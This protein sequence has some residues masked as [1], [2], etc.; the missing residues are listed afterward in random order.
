MKQAGKKT[1]DSYYYSFVKACKL[2][3]V[4]KSVFRQAITSIRKE[5]PASYLVKLFKSGNMHVKPTDEGRAVIMNFLIAN[6]LV[7]QFVPIDLSM[8]FDVPDPPSPNPSTPI[9]RSRSPDRT[10]RKTPPISDNMKAPP[11]SQLAVAPRA[12]RPRLDKPANMNFRQN[13]G[14]LRYIFLPYAQ[15]CL[16]TPITTPITKPITKP[17]TQVIVSRKLVSPKVGFEELLSDDVLASV[18]GAGESHPF[19]P[20]AGTPPRTPPRQVTVPPTTKNPPPLRTMCPYCHVTLQLEGEAHVTKKTEV[21]ECFV[22]NTRLVYENRGSSS[23]EYFA[24]VL[25]DLEDDDTRPLGDFDCEEGVVETLEKAIQDNELVKNAAVTVHTKGSKG[26]RVARNGWLLCDPEVIQS[27]TKRMPAVYR[28][29][30]IYINRRSL[31]V[32]FYPPHLSR[33]RSRSPFRVQ[34]IKQMAKV[35]RREKACDLETMQRRMGLFRYTNI[36]PIHE[37]VKYNNLV[38]SGGDHIVA[39][40]FRTAITASDLRRLAPGNKLNDKLMD[41]YNMLL[42]LRFSK[43]AFA[44]YAFTTYFFTKLEQEPTDAPLP[45]GRGGRFM[46]NGTFKMKLGTCNYKGVMGWTQK[47]DLFRYKLILIPVHIKHPTDPDLDHWVLVAVYINRTPKPETSDPVEYKYEIKLLNYD[48]MGFSNTARLLKVKSYLS[49][50]HFR[51]HGL[52]LHPSTWSMEPNPDAPTQYNNVDCGVH[53][54]ATA[55]CLCSQ[56]GMDLNL[57]KTV[58]DFDE[59]RK[60]IALSIRENAIQNRLKYSSENSDLIDRSD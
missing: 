16:T 28:Y 24:E 23:D 14:Y 8:D 57:F 50:E 51:H 15:V 58:D 37:T 52:W 43:P 6:K 41:F 27:S 20:L 1:K 40:G 17:I 49:L 7:K 32:Q 33:S 26:N 13:F 46:R 30:V 31:Q 59:M 21:F 55:Y 22:C 48:S 44:I 3:R 38:A 60:H 34:D 42:V 53:V 45:S 19:S 39:K 36:H 12:K 47:V 54:C 29:S 10:D 18:G 2:A 11:C 35:S 9:T 5:R 56:L 25:Y 4:K